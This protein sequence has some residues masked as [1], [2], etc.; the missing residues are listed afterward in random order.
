MSGVVGK[1]KNDTMPLC[2]I[3]PSC[4]LTPS[5]TASSPIFSPPLMRALKACGLVPVLTPGRKLMNCTA[6]RGV[7][8]ATSRGNSL[9]TC[10]E[11]PSCLAPLSTFSCPASATTSTLVVVSPTCQADIGAGGLIGTQFDAMLNIF[12]KA[13]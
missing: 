2:D 6:L 1:S 8:A 11:M 4:M 10:G 9:M 12:G 5:I 7:P 3:V 13:L